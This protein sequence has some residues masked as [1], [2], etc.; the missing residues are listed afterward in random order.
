MCRALAQ[1][2]VKVAVMDIRPEP[3]Q[4]LVNEIQKAGGTALA[5]GGNVLDKPSLEKERDTVLKAWG[6]VDFLLRSLSFGT[7]AVPRNTR[8]RAASW[9]PAEPAISRDFISTRAG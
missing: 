3:T 5:L 7:V 9:V 1:S 8:P 2:G 6:R 4:A